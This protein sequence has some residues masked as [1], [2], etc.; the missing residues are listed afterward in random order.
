MPGGEEIL[1]ASRRFAA[2]WGSS[3]GSDRGAALLTEPIECSGADRRAVGGVFEAHH[4]PRALGYRQ[5]SGGAATSHAAPP[6]GLTR[7]G[8]RPLAFGDGA[9]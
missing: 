1:S 3:G 2:R 7:K 9:S 4:R 8:Q 5:H 6:Y